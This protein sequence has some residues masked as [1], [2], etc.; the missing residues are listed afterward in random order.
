MSVLLVELKCGRLCPTLLLVPLPYPTLSPIS[1]TK[2]S[3]TLQVGFDPDFVL[4]VL[5]V[6][7]F[8]LVSDPEVALLAWTT[9]PW[10]L[11]SNLALC[12]NPDFEYVKIE[13]KDTKKKYELLI[14]DI[15]T[16]LGIF[17]SSSDSVRYI[18]I[19]R[20]RTTLYWRL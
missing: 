12:V 9:T 2:R 5:V 6:V 4:I 7:S 18:P 14:S 16:L 15:L 3:E 19:S 8:P 10:T 11:P 13:D 17:F 20:N 1:T